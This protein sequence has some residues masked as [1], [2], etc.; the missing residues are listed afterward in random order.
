MV[1]WGSSSSSNSHV[2]TTKGGRMEKNV[3]CNS[4]VHI[5]I[6]MRFL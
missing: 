5:N 6:L 3:I 2:H 1:P 4:G